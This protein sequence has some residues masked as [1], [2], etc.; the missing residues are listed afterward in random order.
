MGVKFSLSGGKKC[1]FASEICPSSWIL[2][3]Y[4]D[5]AQGY[6]AALANILA[7]CTA[8]EPYSV[9]RAHYTRQKRP[10]PDPPLLS[11][12][13]STVQSF[14]LPPP[15]P[16]SLSY[17]RDLISNCF[18]N[19]QPPSTTPPALG[20]GRMTVYQ[21]RM[22]S[23]FCWPYFDCRRSIFFKTYDINNFERLI[24][25]LYRCNEIFNWVGIKNVLGL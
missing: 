25:H 20:N 24:S 10:F 13:S 21:A 6:V 16:S 8:W 5:H 18:P 4:V 23:A 19:Q 2:G 12:F 7:N 22:K 17:P 9:T 1:L 14:F 11:P 15:S 3:V